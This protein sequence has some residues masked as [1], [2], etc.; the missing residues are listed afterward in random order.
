M[1]LQHTACRPAANHQLFKRESNPSHW[2]LLSYTTKTYAYHYNSI[3]SQPTTGEHRFYNSATLPR[4]DVNATSATTF[5]LSYFIISLIWSIY[6]F[7]KTLVINRTHALVVVA[8][9]RSEYVVFSRWSADDNGGRATVPTNNGKPWIERGGGDTIRYCHSVAVVVVFA[10]AVS[11]WD[12]SL[13]SVYLS[14]RAQR[15]VSVRP[16]HPC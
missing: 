6:H 2:Y 13:R 15:Y 4:A 3:V 11:S 5:N 16:R 10:F 12:E 7:N 8:V 14:L 9:V 1:A